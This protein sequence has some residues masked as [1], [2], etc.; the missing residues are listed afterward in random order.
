L[1]YPQL[2]TSI[3]NNSNPKKIEGSCLSNISAAINA[4]DLQAILVVDDPTRKRALQ[5]SQY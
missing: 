5:L 3:K 2:K 4:M 1:K